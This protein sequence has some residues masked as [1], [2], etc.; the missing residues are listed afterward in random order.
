MNTPHNTFTITPTGVGQYACKSHNFPHISGVGKTPDEAWDN[1]NRQLTY[2]ADNH[3]QVFQKNIKDRLAK[4]L[5]CNCGIKL[6]EK[7]I[8]VLDGQKLRG[9]S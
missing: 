4:G 9:V 1:M 3:K 2:M 8:A 5:K 6:D 7:P